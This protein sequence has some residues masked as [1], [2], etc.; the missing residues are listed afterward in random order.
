L[1]EPGRHRAVGRRWRGVAG[2]VVRLRLWQVGCREC[3]K[4]FAPLLLM[5]G[6]SGKRRTDRL[7]V[8]LAELSAQMS[9]ARAARIA[10][11][12]GVPAT[13]GR[14]YQSMADVAALLGSGGRLA[15]DR[16]DVALFD[17]TLV[18]SGTTQRGQACNVVLGLTGRSGPLRRRRAHTALLGLT[19]GQDWQAMADQL[20]DFP[21]PALVVVDG[22][23]AITAAV[24]A[25]WP[26][27]PIQRCWWHLTTGLR[28]ALKSVPYSLPLA[29][30]SARELTALLHELTRSGFT[31]DD[32]LVAYD[33]FTRGFDVSGCR[34]ATTYLRLARPHVF[35][36]FDDK[37]RHQLRHLGGP[38]IGTG[39]LERTMRQINERVDIGGS[40]WSTDGMRDVVTVL[41]S[42]LTQHPAW[43]HLQNATHP[44]NTI[45]FSVAKLNAG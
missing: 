19:I 39:V 23:Q 22:E 20:R 38:E 25:V 26:T 44:A 13:P 7:A 30:A 45:P 11:G 35:T 32:A 27:T 34:T 33:D 21:A 9:F 1:D 29:K 18:R 3:N 10:R 37:L 24:E 4:V 14:A 31:R 16:V 43:Q 17:G 6:V 15:V 2:G 42:R 40:R 12:F 28:L 8:D 36:C 5:L 41:L